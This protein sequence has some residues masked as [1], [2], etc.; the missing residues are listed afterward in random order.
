MNDH[1]IHL[2]DIIENRRTIKP[3]QYTGE[4]VSDA[5][6]EDILASANWAPTH[7]YTEPWRF[8]VF[9]E[10][11][12]ATLGEFLANLDQP[13]QK[14]ED[15]N[16]MRYDR[17]RNTPLKCSHVIGIGMKRG[18]NPKIPKVEE[19][20]SVAMAVQNMWLTAHA[21][22]LGSY[23][24]TGAM[25]FTDEMRDFFGLSGEDISLGLFY[26]GKPAVVHPTGRRLSG[27]EEKVR[28]VRD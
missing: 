8:S 6:T 22:G 26:I 19:I 9:T 7:G 14:V 2:K 11:G 15:F 20:C 27:I 1:L 23:W 12:L 13:D 17:L 24:S 25:A 3:D 10:D 5:I 16:Q 18:G 21:H 4:R 28:W